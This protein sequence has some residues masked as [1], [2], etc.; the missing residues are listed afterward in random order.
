VATDEEREAFIAQCRWGDTPQCVHCGSI[1]ILTR[2]KEYS[3]RCLYGHSHEYTPGTLPP[4]ECSKCTSLNEGTGL[5]NE[6]LLYKHA[7]RYKCNDCLQ[8]FSAFTGTIFQDTGTSLE[9]WFEVIEAFCEGASNPHKVA[10]RLNVPYKGIALIWS[11]L[12]KVVK[13]VNS[14]VLTGKVQIDELIAGPNPQQDMMLTF[15]LK[16]HKKE[17]KKLQEKYEEENPNSK[18]KFKPT[19]YGHQKLILNMIDSTGKAISIKTGLSKADLTAAKIR[20]ILNRHVAPDAAIILDDHPI[21]KK[22]KKEMKNDIVLIKHGDKIPMLDKDGNEMLDK[23]GNP[24]KRKV[25]TFVD[26]EGNHTNTLEN[27][28][29]H[30]NSFLRRYVHVSQKFTQDYLDE[31]SFLYNNHKK[32]FFGKFLL[33]F[34]LCLNKTVSEKDIRETFDDDPRREEKEA[35][36]LARNA[37]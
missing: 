23:N 33:L 12:R 7:Q 25:K 13:E 28:N 35:R 11:K 9:I 36:R 16:T 8:H 27:M 21:H 15:A 18:E 31:F 32:P 17:Q 37:A 24:R 2:L 30:L 4:E 3:Y 5:P 34:D 20:P 22:L 14:G 10:E 19:P 26:E 29:K 6:I 1:R